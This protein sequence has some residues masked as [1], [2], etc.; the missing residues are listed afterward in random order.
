MKK[1]KNFKYVFLMA[2]A[3]IVGFSSC[4]SDDETGGGVDNTPKNV[5]VRVSNPSTYGEEATAVG[6]TPALNDL[7]V[8]F[9]GGGVIKSIGTMTAAEVTGTGKTFTGVP[10]SA[11]EVVIIG[12]ATAL[13]SPNVATIAAN[14]PVSK[15]NKLMFEQSKQ[16]DPTTAVNVYGEAAIA[17]TPGLE[18]AAVTLTPAI[19]RIEIAEVKAKAAA[20]GVIELTSFKLAGIYINNAY[21]ECGTDYSELPVDAAKVLNY[22]PDATVWTNGSYPARFKDEWTNPSAGTT[23]T[24]T[25]SG[26][27]WSYYVMPVI[28]GKGTTI[29]TE[30]QTSVPHIVLKITDAVAAGYTFP[31]PA[32]ITV[33]DIQVLGQSLTKLE[34]GKVYSIAS[35]AIGGENLAATPETPAT[36]DVSVKATLTPWSNVPVDPIIP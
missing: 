13:T 22:A 35:L 8:Y 27:K 12:N 16:T 2:A 23:F 3:I 28:D 33:K 5:T 19:A 6:Q 34:K 24:P 4:S 20:A 32:Y 1:M 31:S 26:E 9:V 10:G 15:L 17:G 25:A 14:D 7:H 18:T 29:N 21:T 36:Q 11:T 30:K